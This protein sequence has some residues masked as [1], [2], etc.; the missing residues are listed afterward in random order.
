[1]DV[2]MG[3]DEPRGQPK[4]LGYR[5]GPEDRAQLMRRERRATRIVAAV[6]CV[7]FAA[8]A[9][10]SSMQPNDINPARGSAYPSAA[11]TLAI[12]GSIFCFVVAIG[13]FDRR[14]K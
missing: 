7:I 6:F 1:M 13:V 4:T 3:E 12:A 8:A 10:Y 2:A 14:R 11:T 5:S 9:V